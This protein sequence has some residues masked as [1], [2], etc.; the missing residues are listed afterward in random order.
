MG[1]LWSSIFTMAS[2]Q[3]GNGNIMLIWQSIP[4][5]PS[6]VLANLFAEFVQCHICVVKMSIVKFHVSQSTVR[7]GWLISRCWG[8]GSEWK[9]H[10]PV[11]LTLF[12]QHKLKAWSFVFSFCYCCSS[13]RLPSSSSDPFSHLPGQQLDYIFQS[14][15]H[16]RVVT[17]LRSS[18]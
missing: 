8:L 2:A 7:S 15:L 14:H 6:W 18:P 3:S 11:L 16:F 5:I 1:C 4:S 12:K 9:R 17:G 13:Q 10:R